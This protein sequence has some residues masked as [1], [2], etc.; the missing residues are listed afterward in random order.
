MSFF[1][2]ATLSLN[3]VESVL[4]MSEE[5]CFIEVVSVNLVVSFFIGF[6]IL[7]LAVTGF[8]AIGESASRSL[9]HWISP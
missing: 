5:S 2:A 4:V 3:L 6:I 8:A 9:D 7:S 1:T